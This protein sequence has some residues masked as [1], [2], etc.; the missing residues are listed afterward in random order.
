M[1][2]G[3]E[4]IKSDPITSMQNMLKA[5]ATRTEKIVHI[6]ELVKHKALSAEAGIIEIDR[7]IK[8]TSFV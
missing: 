8:E 5:Y 6:T 1:K 2:I 4:D 7:I 3:D